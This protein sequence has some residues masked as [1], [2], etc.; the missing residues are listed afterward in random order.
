MRE[1]NDL[2]TMLVATVSEVLENHP[3]SFFNQIS[4]KDL[5]HK[6]SRLK[7]YRKVNVLKNFVRFTG[8]QLCQTLFFNKVAC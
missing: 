4:E 1:P 3:E 6:G 8:K 2:E 5:K 7:V